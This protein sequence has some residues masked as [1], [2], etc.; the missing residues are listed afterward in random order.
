MAAH[1]G[2]QPR[3]VA[4]GASAC[5]A[6]HARRGRRRGSR[7]HGG[8]TSS[9][10]GPWPRCAHPRRQQAQPCA[11]AGA[12]DRGA[13]WCSS[14]NDAVPCDRHR[15]HRHRMTGLRRRT[16]PQLVTVARMGTAP[17]TVALPRR[18]LGV[19]V[20][21]RAPTRPPRRPR[22]IAV[23]RLRQ[24]PLRPLR[25][26]SVG[27]ARRTLGR[28]ARWLDVRR[29]ALGG[30]RRPR[31]GAPGRRRRSWRGCSRSWRGGGARAPV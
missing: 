5:H 23:V 1:A 15:R 26:D 31:R 21:P 9:P 17:S 4:A 3:S 22:G 18:I 13:W 8:T 14:R 28:H 16:R 29:R 12:T 11:R 24:A 27:A 20:G 2:P 30:G 25:G 7:G 6:T 19:P 10:P